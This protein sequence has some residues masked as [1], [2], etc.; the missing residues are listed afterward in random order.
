MSILLTDKINLTLGDAI[1]GMEKLPN[2]SFDLAI[3]DPPYGAATEKKW[4]YDSKK[5][6]AG[7]GGSWNL[8]NEAWDLFAVGSNTI[9]TNLIDLAHLVPYSPLSFFTF[10]TFRYLLVIF[11]Y[12]QTQISP[13]YPRL[14][15]N[16]K[17]TNAV[18]RHI[19]RLVFDLIIGGKRSLRPSL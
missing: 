12:P 16:T 9:R 5:C 6:L 19:L 1:V 8:N 18:S 7:F 3:C 13:R 15:L 11:K 4:N 10:K 17:L 2:K 14:A